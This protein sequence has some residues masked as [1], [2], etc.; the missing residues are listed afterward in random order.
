M[1]RKVTWI[2]CV[3][4][5]LGQTYLWTKYSTQY[6]SSTVEL[7]IELTIASFFLLG[8]ALLS[9]KFFKTKIQYSLSLICISSIIGIVSGLLLNNIQRNINEKTAEELILT[10]ED[11][12]KDKGH[13]PEFLSRLVPEYFKAEPK[14]TYGLTKK[15]FIYIV[16]QDSYSDY[17]IIMDLGNKS[18]KSWS[19]GN[20]SWDFGGE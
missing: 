5:F 8:L 18:N 12:K 17:T 13:Y 14:L 10:L 9:D 6:I 20:N 4:A 7:S 15:D 3:I 11:Y 1:K 16:T 19:S 2:L